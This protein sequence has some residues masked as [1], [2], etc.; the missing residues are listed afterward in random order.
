ML[1][2]LSPE[3]AELDVNAPRVSMANEMYLNKFKK[4]KPKYKKDTLVRIKSEKNTF[5]KGYRPTFNNEI[6]KIVEVKT[7]LPILS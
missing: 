5:H 6:F 2:G 3:E 4:R 1:R 7:K